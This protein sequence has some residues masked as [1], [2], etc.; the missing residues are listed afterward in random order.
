MAGPNMFASKVGGIPLLLQ[1]FLNSNSHG[2]GHTNPYERSISPNGGCVQSVGTCD[3]SGESPLRHGERKGKGQ[4][5]R[6]T[7]GE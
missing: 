1:R 3:D 7:A 4:A 2:N 6:Q 5:N